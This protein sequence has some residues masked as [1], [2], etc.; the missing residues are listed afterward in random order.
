MIES[1]SENALYIANI[2]SDVITTRLYEGLNLDGLASKY[3]GALRVDETRQYIQADFDQALAY[4][5]QQHIERL[6]EERARAANQMA[7]TL[8]GLTSKIILAEI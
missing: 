3:A 6:G 5:T 7:E 8:I 2:G 4:T 1:I